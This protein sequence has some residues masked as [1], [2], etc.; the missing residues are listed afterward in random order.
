MELPHLADVVRQEVERVRQGG[1]VECFAISRTLGR[2][3]ALAAVG[4]RAGGPSRRVAL[5]RRAAPLGELG[6]H[7][8][9]HPAHSILLPPV[10]PVMV[11]TP[12]L[13]CISRCRP[14]A[15]IAN[16]N[17]TISQL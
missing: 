2:D 3:P 13:P 12:P 14:K 4:V 15:A 5:S 17:A 16:I 1:F 11:M 6:P 8:R 9:R 10:E 7:F